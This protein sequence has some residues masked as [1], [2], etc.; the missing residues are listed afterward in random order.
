MNPVKEKLVPQRN[1][2]PNFIRF[3]SIFRN[4]KGKLVMANLLHLSSRPEMIKRTH[5]VVLPKPAVAAFK[6]MK[7]EYLTSANSVFQILFRSESWTE[8]AS[9]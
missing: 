8:E 6:S 1:I 7:R 5:N 9:R 3:K 2:T 4:T